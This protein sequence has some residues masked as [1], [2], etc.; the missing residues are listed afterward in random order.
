M[1]NIQKA[2]LKVILL[3]LILGNLAFN[4]VYGQA[5]DKEKVFAAFNENFER[6]NQKNTCISGL[7]EIR[8]AFFNSKTGEVLIAAHR[9]DHMEAPENSIPSFLDAAKYGTAIVELDIR[10]SSDDSLMV[11]HDGTVDRTTT[12][13]GKVDSQTFQNLRNY[14]LINEF[15]GDTTD[16]KIPTLFESLAELKGKVMVDLDIK[17]DRIK[18]IYQVVEKLDMF[19]Q[20][21]FFCDE[22]DM[23]YVLSKNPK[24]LVMPRA[25]S[26]ESLEKLMNK[27]NPSIIHIDNKNFDVPS[28]VTLIKR[29]NPS[30]RI[31]A[32]SL[33]ERD[34][35][36]IFGDDSG[37][38]ELANLGINVIQT[39]LP[40][41][42][43]S[44]LC[45]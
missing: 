4:S 39:D 21:I 32:N 10:N 16:L 25:N 36:A 28:A 27:Y 1:K 37:I 15:T 42:A 3:G 2:G 14:T 8:E 41:Y 11:I 30:C 12:G 43:G 24:A 29:I 20:S 13:K 40:R 23:D 33:G 34:I 18:E 35:K 9:G 31:W 5:F 6:L 19:D 44:L 7:N 26:M 17:C 22:A 45:N 38:E